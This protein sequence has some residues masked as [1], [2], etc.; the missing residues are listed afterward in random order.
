MSAEEDENKIKELPYGAEYA[1]SGRSSCKICKCPIPK[2]G[3]LF[4]MIPYM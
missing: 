3:S 4:C 2:V 1:K